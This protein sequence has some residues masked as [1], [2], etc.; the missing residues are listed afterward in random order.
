VGLQWRFPG[1]LLPIFFVI[2]LAVLAINATAGVA[3]DLSRSVETKNNLASRA[4]ELVGH[5]ACGHFSWD[6][7]VDAQDVFMTGS[8]FFLVG[9]TSV[10]TLSPT[11]SD[12]SLRA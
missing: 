10:A 1:L 7:F 11:R 9:L 6:F 5:D 3:L 8:S 12:P 2:F 4:C